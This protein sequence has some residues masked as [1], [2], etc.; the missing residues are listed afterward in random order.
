MYLNADK[1]NTII[2]IDNLSIQVDKW[3]ILLKN[4]LKAV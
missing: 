2:I 3:F 1:T 4:I